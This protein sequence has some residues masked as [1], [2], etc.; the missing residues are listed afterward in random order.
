MLKKR[1]VHFRTQGK[2][3]EIDDD[4]VTAKLYQDLSEAT[5]VLVAKA[6]T[7]CGKLNRMRDE[8]YAAEDRAGIA[9]PFYGGLCRRSSRRQ[10]R[11]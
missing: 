8:A 2:R 10:T 11:R 5:K 4:E 1:A 3:R 7:W 9:G 6:M